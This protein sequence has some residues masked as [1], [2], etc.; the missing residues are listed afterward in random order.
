MLPI[1]LLKLL[2]Q[3][4]VMWWNRK[5]PFK[6]SGMQQFK[7]FILLPFSYERDKNKNKIIMQMQFRCRCMNQFK[8]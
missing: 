5:I 4:F 2:F 8:L 1:F 6:F 3:Y 7:S